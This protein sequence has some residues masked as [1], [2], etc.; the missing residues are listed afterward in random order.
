MEVLTLAGTRW[1]LALMA[2]RAP[3]VASGVHCG[4]SPLAAQHKQ[5]SLEG[6]VLLG[7]EAVWADQTSIVAVLPNSICRRW[8]VRRRH[9]V[10]IWLRSV[11]LQRSRSGKMP[12]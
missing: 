6:L 1:N 10:G 7:V 11:I 8:E 5:T 12:F 2:G 3:N 4:G 9:A